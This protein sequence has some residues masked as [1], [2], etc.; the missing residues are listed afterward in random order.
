MQF[1]IKNPLYEPRL[2]AIIASFIHPAQ[3]L[4]ERDLFQKALRPVI[5][6][7][8]INDI[9]IN[10]ECSDLLKCQFERNKRDACEM[11]RY[12]QKVMIVNINYKLH[13]D[14]NFNYNCWVE[15]RKAWEAERENLEY[16]IDYTS[17]DEEDF[18]VYT[19]YAMTPRKEF[20]HRVIVLLSDSIPC[21]IGELLHEDGWTVIDEDEDEDDPYIRE[22]VISKDGA[23]MVL[24]FYHEIV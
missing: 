4:F 19:P 20:E 7:G 9:C 15:E 21:N 12:R 17:G 3:K 16:G 24:R 8:V 22:T 18:M 2:G 6:D 1:L 11:A 10:F 23:K 13:F 5:M 14:E